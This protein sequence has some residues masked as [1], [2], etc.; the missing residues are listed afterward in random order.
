LAES[1]REPARKAKKGRGKKT[2]GGRKGCGCLLFVLIVCM[3]SLGALVHPFSLRSLAGCLRYQDR[4]VPA[5]VIVVPRF[6][7]DRGGELY[8]EAFREYWSGNGKSIVIEDDHVL[9]FTLKD[10]IGRLAKERGIK[11]AVVRAIETEGD[12]PTRAA[13]IKEA[14]KKQ[15]IRKIVLV[16]PSYSSRRFHSL[17]GSADANGMMFLVKAV[18]VSYFRND[19]WWKKSLSRSLVWRETYQ[20]GALFF[21]HIRHRKQGTSGKE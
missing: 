2:Q 3:V 7:E 18:D 14:L 1:V 16:V 20:T 15:G 9:G 19:Q 4:I 21:D 17:Y 8:T 10:I 6:P 5:D 13:G 11:E 12:D